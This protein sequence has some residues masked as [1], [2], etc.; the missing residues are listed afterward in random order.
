[1]NRLQLTYEQSV[2]V[3]LFTC[4]WAM[5]EAEAEVTEQPFDPEAVALSFMG[6]GASTMVTVKHLRT[7][8]DVMNSIVA[9]SS[10]P[11]SERDA[12]LSVAVAVND[13]GATVIVSKHQGGVQT[14]VYSETHHLGYE[15]SAII[16]FADAQQV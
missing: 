8:C 13:L 14:V 9:P 3:S 11:D 12:A 5:L 2:A 1:M 16:K 15:G 4:W 7:V 10:Q 6:C